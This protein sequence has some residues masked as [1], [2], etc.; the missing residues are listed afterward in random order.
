MLRYILTIINSMCWE[1]WAL[2]ANMGVCCWFR[3]LVKCTLRFVASPAVVAIIIRV[4]IGLFS[5]ISHAFVT[6]SLPMANFVAVKAFAFFAVLAIA[7][8]SCAIV[9]IIPIVIIA[10]STSTSVPIPISPL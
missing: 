5:F 7:I 9:G 1:M 2:I 10:V 4:I 8:L 6:I 3:T